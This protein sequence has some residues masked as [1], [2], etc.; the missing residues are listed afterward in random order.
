MIQPTEPFTKFDLQ[1]YGNFGLTDGITELYIYGCS[2][3]WNG[4]TK[5]FG[6]LGV[7]EGDLLKVLATKNTYKGLVQGVAVYVSHTPA[8]PTE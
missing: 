1:T 6:T 8:T 5:K 2:T 4:E 3:G 7:N